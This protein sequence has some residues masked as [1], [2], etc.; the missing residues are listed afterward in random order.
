MQ[1]S[2]N[3]KLD[4]TEAQVFSDGLI[5]DRGYFDVRMDFDDHIEGEI[6]IKAKDPLDI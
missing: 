2:D 3:N 4:W 6:R 1:I 5:M